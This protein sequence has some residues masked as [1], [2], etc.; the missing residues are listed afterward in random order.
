[1]ILFLAALV[2]AASPDDAGRLFAAVQQA[3]AESGVDA[4]TSLGGRSS[5]SAITALLRGYEACELAIAEVRAKPVKKRAEREA[6]AAKQDR[7]LTIRAAIES[8]VK[9]MRGTTAIKEFTARLRG[10]GG[11]SMRAL[12]AEALGGQFDARA[13]PSI[14]AQLGKERD[15]RVKVA[16]LDVI[17][18]RRPRGGTILTR[19]TKALKDPSWTVVVAAAHAMAEIGSKD[20]VDPLIAALKGANG[21]VKSDLNKALAAI[22]GV[23]KHGAHDVWKDW[24]TRNQKAV[25]DGTYVPEPAERAGAAAGGTTFYGLP[26]VSLSPV[27]VI[28]ASLSMNGKSPWKP[29]G[30]VKIPGIEIKGDRKIDVASY[31]LKKVI[32]M[33]PD[34]AQFN[35]VFFHRDAEALSAPLM[36]TL[37]KATRAR[38][39][40]WIDALELKGQT[41]I[42]KGMEKAFTFAGP[43]SPNGG[44]DTFYLLSDGQPT[45]GIKETDEFCRAIAQLNRGLKIVIHTVAIKPT[46][47]SGAFLKAIADGNGGEYAARGA[48]KKKKKKEKP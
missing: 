36:V 43:A 45:T 16:L 3:D 32:H 19:L 31:E 1:M 20:A 48:R 9:S 30:D 40:A 21:R 12:M 37:N 38:A 15:P 47:T 18:R 22:T 17:A 10:R 2:V 42:F 27:F 44:P 14:V 28:D 24:W 29:T 6:T 11:P 4:A 23:D 39:Y 13:L 35:I 8:A 7:L 41:N 33:L 34:G 25:L 26:V 46:A 5:R